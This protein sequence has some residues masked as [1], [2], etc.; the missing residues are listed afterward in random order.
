MVSLETQIAEQLP[1]DW[2][3]SNLIF[4]DNTWQVNA[5]DNEHV[6]VATGAT[7][8]EALDNAYIKADTGE[9][10]G[11]LFSLGRIES[12]DHMRDSL[13]DLLATLPP[14]K[15]FKRRF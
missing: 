12:S 4:N 13:A 3:L 1:P 14:A 6:V 7:I 9:F 2:Q 15:P 8:S 5:T 11:R 10:N